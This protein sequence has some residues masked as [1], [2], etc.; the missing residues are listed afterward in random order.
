M[1]AQSKYCDSLRLMLHSRFKLNEVH[2]LARITSTSIAALL[3]LFLSID[4]YTLSLHAFGSQ[5][6]F[7]WSPNRHTPPVSRR[8]RPGSHSVRRYL[9]DSGCRDRDFLAACFSFYHPR[10]KSR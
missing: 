5:P 8:S 3:S 9:I 10:K 2:S 7:P 6:F 4:L 1:H